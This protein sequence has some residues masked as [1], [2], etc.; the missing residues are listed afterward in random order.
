M[1]VAPLPGR[2]LH[3]TLGRPIQILLVEDSA[4]DAFMTREALRE[5]RVLNQIET[6][7]DGEQ[8]IAYLRRVAPYEDVARPD[9]ILLDFNLPRKDGREVLAEVKADGHLSAIPIVVL[10]TSAAE[11]DIARAYK[12]QAN[13]YVTKPVDFDQ[14][15][16]AVANIENFWLSLVRLPTE[17]EEAQPGSAS[18]PTSAARQQYQESRTIRGRQS[19]ERLQAPTYL[20]A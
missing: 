18:A 4:S 2:M 11:A 20:S 3:A 19:G 13:A 14:F 6:V 10:T 9:L 12:L 1:S 16:R 8:A 15:M 7:T 17:P 5:G